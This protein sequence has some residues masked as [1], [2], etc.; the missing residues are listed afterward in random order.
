M[1]PRQIALVVDAEGLAGVGELEGGDRVLGGGRVEGGGEIELALH[2]VGLEGR[3]I[4]EDLRRRQQVEAGVD[5]LRGQL[6]GARAGRLDDPRQA[7]AVGERPAQRSRLGELRHRQRSPGAG[8]GRHQ[9]LEGGGAHQRHIARQDQQPR[10]SG[11]MPLD[12][13]QRVPGAELLSLLHPGDLLAGEPLAHRGSAVSDDRQ[14][15]LAAGGPGRGEH[16]LQHRPSRHRV[17]HLGPRR[18]Q[19][20]PLA[21]G[22]NHRHQGPGAG[23]RPV[24]VACAGHP[25]LGP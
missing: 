18:A 22:E 24:G 5:P 19:P 9:G 23:V 2:R 1:G 8:G 16:P 25:L 17:Q 6:A 21:G 11:E 10:R 15:P 3:E 13:Q 4:G 7:A 12:L 14:L 20:R